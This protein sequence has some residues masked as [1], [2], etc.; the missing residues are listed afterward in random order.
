MIP[1][2]VTFRSERAVAAV[3]S[4]GGNRT[5]PVQQDIE[6]HVMAKIYVVHIYFAKKQTKQCPVRVACVNEA[7]SNF[8]KRHVKVLNAVGFL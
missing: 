6:H 5:A 4:P 3:V 7:K 2:M 8:N 1:W